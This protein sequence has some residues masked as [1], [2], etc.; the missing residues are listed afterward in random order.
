MAYFTD[1]AS[2]YPTSSAH[3]EFNGY[4]FLDQTSATEEANY[5]GPY[6]TFTDLW[7]TF[8]RPGPTVGSPTTLPATVSIVVTFSPTGV[9]TPGPPESL[10]PAISYPDQTDGYGQPPYSSYY[11]PEVGQQTQSYDSGSLS[12]DF[13]STSMAVPEPFTAV[14]TPSSGKRLFSL[15]LRALEYL[16]I[17]NS[18]VRLLGGKP[19]RAL[20]RHVL[21]GKC[22]GSFIII[23]FR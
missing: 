14:P 21:Y 20:Y 2:F 19:E 12:H 22:W 9:L 3:E 17:A 6:S 8:E 1:Y 16:P 5:Q 11:W 15:K 23:Q 10:A 18:P 13:S 7:N 4:Q